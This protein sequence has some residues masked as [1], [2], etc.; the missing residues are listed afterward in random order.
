MNYSTGADSNP[1]SLAV[2]NLNSDL[3]QDLVVANFG[4][5]NIGIFFGMSNGIFKFHTTLTAGSSRPLCVS[6][7]DFNNDGHYDIATV[8]YG[9]DTVGIFLGHGNGSFSNQITF[10]TGYDSLPVS[11]VIADFNYDNAVD[12]GV[13]N[14]G[15]NNI[16]VFLGYGNG[17]FGIPTLLTTGINSHPYSIAVADFNNDLQL[18]IVV[19][20]QG[21]GNGSFFNQQTYSIGSGSYPIFVTT[22]DFNNDKRT[23]S[24]GDD[25]NPKSIAMTYFNDDD[26]MDMAVANMGTSNVGILFGSVKVTGMGEAIS[27]TGSAP[28]PQS[29]A[30]GDLNNDSQLD[31]IVGNYGMDNIKIFFGDANGTFLTQTIFSTGFLSL[32]TSVVVKDLNNNNQ[33][34]IVIANSGN[35]NIGILFGHG[36]GSFDGPITYYTDIGSNPQSVDIGDFNGDDQL[37]IVVANY[38]SKS[39]NILLKYDPRAF[40]SMIW[41]STGT[42]SN[43]NS[44]AIGDLNNDGRLDIVVANRGSGNIGIFFGYDNGTFSRQITFSIGSSSRPYSVAINDFNNDSRLDIAV[45]N[46]RSDE[47]VI[48]LGDGD[49]TFTNQMRYSTGEDSGSIFIVVGDFNNDKRLDLAVANHASANVGIL[50][51]YGNGSF[52]NQMSYSTGSNSFP[53]SVTVGD[54]NHDNWLDFA[55]VNYATSNL[56]I[57]LG[58][59]DGTFS[60]QTTYSTGVRSKPCFITTVDLNNDSRL[61]LVVANYKSNNIGIFIGH[62]NGTFSSQTAY[63][64]GSG[65]GPNSIIIGDFNN[66]GLLDIVVANFL[67]N[68]IGVLL[69]F[70]ND[71]FLSLLTYSTGDASQPYSVVAGDFNNDGRLDMAVANYGSNNVGVF[72]GYDSRNFLRAPSYSMGNESRPRYVVV[73]DFN[74][75]S[76]LDVVVANNDTDNIMIVFGSGHGTF[77][78]KMMYFTGNGSHPCSIASIFGW[79]LDMDND[80]LWEVA[81]ATADANSIVILWGYSNRNFTHQTTFQNSFGSHPF[82]IAVGDVNQDNLTDVV[83]ANN[84]YGNIGFI[85]KTC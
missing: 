82:A 28:C 50:L 51:G 79:V 48:L 3:Q 54:F 49:G 27:F 68:T 31:V 1:R 5:H 60:N 78:S 53:L 15:T 46:F 14:Y 43:P 66:D 19:V 55:V 70:K 37:D 17:S 4:T 44:A 47:I 9:T 38:G 41:Y 29:I 64:T 39:V 63:S 84:G 85:S 16:G 83:V 42:N 36:N 40:Q 6:V 12:I 74:N 62:G 71:D 72:L 32:P 13:A 30:V 52:R 65:S 7:G 61:D 35:D 34:D 81:I 25:S 45:A 69:G 22:G 73:G 75:D 2:G 23:Y 57:R 59:G 58:H 20:N 21:N 18:D 8:N 77:S 67:G 11:L 80:T 76:R 10:S 33:L 56:G 24:T 26:L